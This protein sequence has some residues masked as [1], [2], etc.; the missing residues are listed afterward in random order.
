ML[1]SAKTIKKLCSIVLSFSLIVTNTSGVLAFDNKALN[2]PVGSIAG[3]AHRLLNQIALEKFAEKAKSDDILK[4]YNFYP[5]K[6]QLNIKGLTSVDDMSGTWTANLFKAEG[7]DVY[8]CGQTV[9]DLNAIERN[10]IKKFA[11]WIIDAGYSA[12]EPERY[13]S[14]RH[15]FNPIQDKGPDYFSDLPTDDNA[16]ANYIE[17]LNQFMGESNPKVNAKTWALS[18]SNNK[19]NW[20]NGIK[21]LEKG[22]A[23]GNTDDSFAAGWRSIG[24]TLHLIDDMTVPAHVRDDSHPA[25]YTGVFDDAR[26]DAYEYLMSSNLQII[27]DNKDQSIV[28]AEFNERLDG[29]NTPNDLFDVVAGYVNKHFFS[30][31][32]IPYKSLTGSLKDLNWDGIVYDEPD[33]KKPQ[34]AS[35]Y[36]DNYV[37]KD[38]AGSLIMYHKSW[39]DDNGWEEVPGIVNL[40]AV[41]SQARRLIPIAIKSSMK[42][43]DM[44]IPRVSID[45]IAFDKEKLT[46]KITRYKRQDN[47]SYVPGEGVNAAQRMI[48]FVTLPDTG[49]QEN[50]LLP[51]VDVKNGQFQ[52]KMSDLERY[53]N[54]ISRYISS[55]R[56]ISIDI[57]LDMGGIL[58]KSVSKV[59][60]KITVEPKKAA[61]QP[62]NTVSFKAKVTNGPKEPYYVWNYGDGS[63]NVSTGNAQVS[64]KYST[65]AEF[66]G[67]VALYDKNNKSEE[68]SRAEFTVKVGEGKPAKKGTPDA[69]AFYIAP[70]KVGLGGIAEGKREWPGNAHKGSTNESLKITKGEWTDRDQNGEMDTYVGGVGYDRT[71]FCDES[72]NP[73]AV[74]SIGVTAGCTLMNFS[75]MG[76][77]INDAAQR[78]KNQVV[79][80][81]NRTLNIDGYT[82][83]IKDALADYDPTEYHAYI[84]DWNL[85][86]FYKYRHW[87]Q[88]QS[89]VKVPEKIN[90][91][92]VFAEWF[93]KAVKALK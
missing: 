32:T 16:V 43:L 34:K 45:G 69:S 47:G 73:Y 82:I 59:K 91:D 6:K 80:Q 75:S 39:L 41:E 60:A 14:W 11:D 71:Y 2:A 89:A 35:K 12:D 37:V 46:G 53:S 49:K 3:G 86:F 22:L 74:N 7:S 92:A 13:M 24:Q 61:I 84:N 18:H 54:F 25:N 58:V 28:N 66:T 88:Y 63:E 77:I 90:S 8:K 38:E 68:L 27:K 42:I 55:D 44:G 26:A 50:F 15:F 79:T 65:E 23:N 78:E 10:N 76:Q 62:E 52:L 83:Y 64:H 30:S 93:K 67:S 51:P 72:I 20:A 70:D 56:D 33:Y 31:D 36:S 87:R 48:V 9:A 40:S 21:S 19:Y 17:S 57:G 85:E 81:A 4:N 5:D 29:I 1:K